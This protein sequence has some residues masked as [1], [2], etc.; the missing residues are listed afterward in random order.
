MHRCQGT[1]AKP[2]PPQA[3]DLTGLLRVYKVPPDLRQSQAA[4]GTHTNQ[5]HIDNNNMKVGWVDGCSVSPW[6]M[7]YILVGD[8][9]GRNIISSPWP[10]FRCTGYCTVWWIGCKLL[11]FINM[12]VY[13]LLFT[14]SL[15]HLQVLV[16]VAA[17][18]C[19]ASGVPAGLPSYEYSPTLPYTPA[20]GYRPDPYYNV[21]L[22]HYLEIVYFLESFNCW[23]GGRERGYTKAYTSL[24]IMLSVV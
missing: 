19:V 18:V 23:R 13:Q 9:G 17:V 21:S 20:L 14:L 3:L 10:A 11:Y 12:L 22:F 7:T 6:I 1:S 5:T 2:N 24:V 4:P 8:R 15:L 16:V